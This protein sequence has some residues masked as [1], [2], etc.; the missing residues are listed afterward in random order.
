MG[1]FLFVFLFIF[2][3]FSQSIQLIFHINNVLKTHFIGLYKKFNFICHYN[4]YNWHE[5]V[6][7]QS[8]VLVSKPLY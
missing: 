4:K 2:I 6:W 1:F 5:Q 7:E 3:Q 8:W